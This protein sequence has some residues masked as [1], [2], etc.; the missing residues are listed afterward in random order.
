MENHYIDFEYSFRSGIGSLVEMRFVKEHQMRIVLMKDDSSNNLEIGKMTFLMIHM[1]QLIES[2]HHHGQLLDAHSEYLAR[3]IFKIFDGD[4]EEFNDIILD[5]YHGDL[6]RLNIC[7]IQ[8]LQI[9]PKYRG[10]QIG[11][12]AIKDLVFHYAAGC[13]LFVVQPYPLQFETSEQIKANKALE[14]EKYT[15]DEEMAGYKL[16]AYYQRM[17]FE[18]IQGIDDLLFYN[19]ALINDKMDKIDLEEE[20]DFEK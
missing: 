18:L 14:L 13:G 9:L 5:H 11:A 3:H 20:V 8:K 7:F 12:K 10:Y 17:G 6:P 1:D 15:D 4:K 2:F 16:V 19:P